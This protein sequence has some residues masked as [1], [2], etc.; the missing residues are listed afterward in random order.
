MILETRASVEVPL[1]SVTLC[2]LASR[3]TI[4]TSFVFA[5]FTQKWTAVRSAVV[6]GCVASFTELTLAKVRRDVSDVEVV[7]LDQNEVQDL[8]FGV[9]VFFSLLEKHWSSISEAYARIRYP[10]GRRCR[11]NF[12]NSSVPQGFFGSTSHV[13]QRAVASMVQRSGFRCRDNDRLTRL[14]PSKPSVW[15][16]MPNTR[17]LAKHIWSESSAGGTSRFLSFLR[18]SSMAK[19]FLPIFL[20]TRPPPRLSSRVTTFTAT[21]SSRTNSLCDCITRSKVAAIFSWLISSTG[22]HDIRIG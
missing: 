19:V 7:S 20:R 17:H 14:G 12:F 10:F 3:L 6:E 16:S 13:P 11:A 9:V 21:S 1:A 15:W 8:G 5:S 2:V 18:F 22:I 4:R